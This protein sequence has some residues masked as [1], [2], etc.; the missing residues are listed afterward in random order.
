M[1][2][3]DV[4]HL[5]KSFGDVHAV[6]D[7]SFTAGPGAITAFLG[8]NGAGKTTTLR[9]IL[10]LVTPTTGT[11]TVGGAPYRDLDRPITMVGA[12][13]EATAFHPGLTAHAHLE[14]IRVAAGLDPSRVAHVLDQ[15]DLTGA[16]HRKVHGFSLGMRQRLALATALLGDPGILVLD[17]PANGLDPAGMR[18]LRGFLRAYAHQGR[19]VLV[20]T[21]VLSEI[22]Q[23]TDQVIIISAGRLLFAGPLPA[24]SDLEELY[25]EVT[26]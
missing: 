4:V 19:T 3:I 7:L 16:A 12:V 24:G 14:A 13:L 20:S 17:E 1:S 10:G 22:Q 18:W 15:V 9:M 2:A 8:P 21:H 25:L 23:I 26:G 5:S 6:D 11:A